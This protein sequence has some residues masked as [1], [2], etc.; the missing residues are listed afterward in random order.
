MIKSRLLKFEDA[1]EVGGG[2]EV[3]ASSLD[4]IKRRTGLPNFSVISI[5]GD[6]R[7]QENSS[8]YLILSEKLIFSKSSII[9]RIYTLVSNQNNEKSLLIYMG[10]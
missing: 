10:T 9:F 1:Y 3:Y 4:R 6:P 7:C 2:T 5:M 8:P